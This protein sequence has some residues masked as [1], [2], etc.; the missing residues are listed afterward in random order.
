[1]NKKWYPSSIVCVITVSLVTTGIYYLTS[2]RKVIKNHATGFSTPSLWPAL[3]WSAMF[4]KFI[5]SDWS[6]FKVWNS[7]IRHK[8]KLQDIV[9][10]ITNIGVLIIIVDSWVMCYESVLWANVDG[11]VNFPIYISDFPSR[12]KQTL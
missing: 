8:I 2:E 9:K 12:V 3:H 5:S 10:F 7:C 1:M 6:K 11:V 4:Y